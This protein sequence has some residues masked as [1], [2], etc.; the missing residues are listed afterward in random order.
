M[1][2]R[3]DYLRLVST[4]DIR[5]LGKNPSL[6]MIIAELQRAIDH[7]DSLIRQ[8]NESHQMVH[9]TYYHQTSNFERLTQ[10]YDRLVMAL[11]KYG[12]IGD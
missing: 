6:D 12:Q 3:K 8:L 9:G 10:R 2:Q 4:R 1:T 11:C 7:T 5:N